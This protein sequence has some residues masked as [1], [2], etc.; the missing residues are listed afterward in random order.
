[1][2]W[3]Y[4]IWT[5]PA[6]K[7]GAEIYCTFY[8]VDKITYCRWEICTRGL[9]QG[10]YQRKFLEA[11]PCNRY[12]T[13]ISFSHIALSTVQDR[14][15][16]LIRT[17]VEGSHSSPALGCRASIGSLWKWTPSACSHGQKAISVHVNTSLSSD[18]FRHSNQ[19]QLKPPVCSWTYNRVSTLPIVNRAWVSH[20]SRSSI[21]VDYKAFLSGGQPP[22][23]DGFA[24]PGRLVWTPDQRLPVGEARGCWT[25]R[26][27]NISVKRQ[28]RQGV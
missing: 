26:H 17:R 8:F 10:R 15:D 12:L 7:P 19:D 27:L 20:R 13:A 11:S 2:A 9:S 4:L 28:M 21:P 22:D 18:N 5:G 6:D 23:F 3:C 25:C 14:Q 16:I 24:P 1:M